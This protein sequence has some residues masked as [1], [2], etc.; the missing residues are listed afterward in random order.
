MNDR[1][2]ILLVEDEDAIRLLAHQVLEEAGFVVLDAVDG[3]AA[4]ELAQG[5]AGGIDLLIS[6][7]ALPLLDGRELAGR[8]RKRFTA[9]KV[10]F[11]SGHEVD[12]EIQQ[13]VEAHEFAYL[14]K[15]FS[16]ADLRAKVEQALV[17]PANH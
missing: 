11:L 3:E 12:A 10:L 17:Q 5:C 9:L 13:G 6:D 2:V 8:L 4:L 16:L 1:K 15:P 7:L 14:Q